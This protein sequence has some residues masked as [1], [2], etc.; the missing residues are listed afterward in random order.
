MLG[1]VADTREATADNFISRS[2]CTTIFPT[3]HP[4]STAAEKQAGGFFYSEIQAAPMT[5]P[6]AAC[7]ALVAV[8]VAAGPIACGFSRPRFDTRARYAHPVPV[9]TVEGV[10]I[11]WPPVAFCCFRVCMNRRSVLCCASP[12]LG[13]VGALVAVASSDLRSAALAIWVFRKMSKVEN[14]PDL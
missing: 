2:A 14:A 8:V 12:A 13:L 9:S 5:T 11:L 10:F 3:D 6:L 4:A 7:K 1:F